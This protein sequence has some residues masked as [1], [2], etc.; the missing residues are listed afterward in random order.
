MGRDSVA[1]QDTLV[2]MND[3]V[4]TLDE[5]GFWGV[6]AI[7]HHFWSEGY[8]IGPSPGIYNAYWAAITKNIHIGQLGYVMSTQ[9]PIRVAEEL[10][11][12][13]HLTKG[14]CF[15][16]F[17]R[18]YQSR[19]TNILGQQTG[20][21]AT[22]S[23]NAIDDGS[24]SFNFSTGAGSAEQMA[25]D[26]ELNRRIFEES[27]EI[28]LKAW[29]S[30]SLEHDGEFWKVPFPYSTGVDDWQ[31]A[32]E[33]VTGRLGAI[34]EVDENN[35]V[36]RIS[37]VPSPY[38]SPH[39][40][41]FVG[42]SGSPQSIEYA[43]QHDFNVGYFTSV[44]RA[45]AMGEIYVEE[46]A[47]QGRRRQLGQNQALIRWMM[48][49]DSEADAREKLLRYDGEIFNNM[50]AGLS[51]QVKTSPGDPVQSMID[52][53]LWVVG[54]VGQVRDTLLE[55][56]RQFPADFIILVSHYAQIPADEQLAQYR[57]FMQEIKPALDEVTPERSPLLLDST[58]K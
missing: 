9:S 7:E 32:H 29:T 34:G 5:I 3:I 25:A 42:V 6:T 2:G 36:R 10:A 53:G 54:S 1:Y 51:P 50:Y 39:P 48:I 18:G 55:H 23:P 28:V 41:V 40:P 56:W 24:G 27:V 12:L 52:T 37:V 45:K 17:A 33:G 20:A 21:R 30:E 26:D 15:A 8:Q 31:L 49:G 11:I 43:A 58:T 19:W 35:S 14:R 46:S 47:A 44:K 38:Q 22:R 13:D 16:G 4:R 57:T